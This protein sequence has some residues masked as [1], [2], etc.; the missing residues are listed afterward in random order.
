MNQLSN[1]KLNSDYRRVLRYEGVF[2]DRER[3][4]YTL[5]ILHDGTAPLEQVRL[6]S[7]PIVISRESE[8]LDGLIQ[9][10]ATVILLSHSD[11]LF[12]HLHTMPEGS[13]KLVVWRDGTLYWLG[14]LDPESY[15]EDYSRKDNYLVELTFSDFGCAKRLRHRYQGVNRLYDWVKK[16]IEASIFH[17]RFALGA[18][19]LPFN[20]YHDIS[21]N[22]DL[23]A[24]GESSFGSLEEEGGEELSLGSMRQLEQFMMLSC[25]SSLAFYKG[26]DESLTIFDSLDGL[27][28]S[29]G[30]RLEQREGKFV[31]YD[32]D[33]LVRQE[34]KPLRVRGNDARFVADESYNAINIEVDARTDVAKKLYR[35]DKVYGEKRKLVYPST[36]D[37]DDDAYSLEVERIYYAPGAYNVRTIPGTFGENEEFIALCLA[38]TTKKIAQIYSDRYGLYHFTYRGN[39]SAMFAGERNYGN[40]ATPD[41]TYNTSFPRRNDDYDRQGNGWEATFTLPHSVKPITHMYEIV[42]R[43]AFLGIGRW[44]DVGGEDHIYGMFSPFAPA[45][46]RP[47]VARLE[48]PIKNTKGLGIRIDAKLFV[49]FLPSIYQPILK[50]FAIGTLVDMGGQRMET[51][52]SNQENIQNALALDMLVGHEVDA[53]YMALRVRAGDYILDMGRIPYIETYKNYTIYYKPRGYRYVY[54]WLRYGD[55]TK[56]CYIYVPFGAGDGE[57]NYGSWTE[58]DHL[59]N[60]LA[61]NG[62]GKMRAS[63]R[64]EGN[65][66]VKS[67]FGNIPEGVG[68]VQVEFLAHIVFGSDI[69]DAWMRTERRVLSTIEERVGAF[70][71]DE[72]VR[73]MYK[74]VHALIDGLFI[75]SYVLLKDLSISLC[76]TTG[77]KLE[78]DRIKKTAIINDRAYEALDVE[79]LLSSDSELPANSPALLI[80]HGGN[81]INDIRRVDW[82]K[83]QHEHARLF[84]EYDTTQLC[85]NTSELLAMRAFSHYG[86]RRH[87]IEGR[88]Q[89]ID[90]LSLVEYAG[91]RYMILNEEADLRVCASEYVLAEI[92]PSSYKPSLKMGS[93]EDGGQTFVLN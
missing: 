10:R 64:V 1:Y 77:A 41:T 11:G 67:S 17:S 59:V 33:W 4:Q 62:D 75:P 72:A 38:P 56:D 21:L 23:V 48:L 37:P 89:S 81:R 12:R 50:Q 30:F 29:I 27:L 39:N 57:Y 45:S 9:S 15:E 66:S 49:S 35:P 76:D 82:S 14:T 63:K 18:G 20:L 16:F 65:N 28:R 71:R 85:S 22:S 93:I 58:I 40:K 73:K 2:T 88:F 92:S 54:K 52:D 19:T 3:R 70:Y 43:P 24:Y 79:P 8:R 7:K 53:M 31:I 34:A 84:W 68:S 78:D 32:V 91:Q 6:G 74:S 87:R 69:L 26:E 61:L 55:D 44:A 5:H 83:P 25:A 60:G 13:V 90:T 46:T 51:M 36:Y 47:V 80:D 86:T 42:S